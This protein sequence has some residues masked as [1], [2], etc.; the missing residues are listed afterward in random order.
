MRPSLSFTSLSS[1]NTSPT[2]VS[3]HLLHTPAGEA[4]DPPEETLHREGN[5]DQC[6]TVSAALQT[7]LQV[8]GESDIYTVYPQQMK[9]IMK[10]YI[11]HIKRAVKVFILVSLF[12]N[13]KSSNN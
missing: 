12:F 6:P 9:C 5:P 10:K 11:S 4:S 7:E 2:H 3:A 8:S 1:M 13:C